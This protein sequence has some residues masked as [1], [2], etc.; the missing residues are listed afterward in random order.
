MPYLDIEGEGKTYY[1]TAGPENGAP[2]LMIHGWCAS[3]R[4]WS[5]QMHALSAS[6]WRCIAFDAL[7]HGRSSK[8]V[9]DLSTPTLFRRLD[10]LMDR[11]GLLGKPLAV[12]G[13]SAGGGIAQY[14]YHRYPEH[15]K[16]LVLL[17]TGYRMRDSLPRTLIWSYGPLYAMAFFNPVT[18]TLIMPGAI[19]SADIT[20]ALL[21]TN[22]N[23]TR[24]WFRDVLRTPPDVAAHEIKE[25]LR[26]ETEHLLQEI[27]AP[28]CIIGS[29]FDPLAPARQSVRMHELIP[30]SELHILHLSGHAGKISEAPRVNRIIKKFLEK[31]YPPKP[32]P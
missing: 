31:H 1:E 5:G 7:G 8:R 18:K 9:R 2:L 29:V 30:D 16:A 24:Q 17:H 4:L 13:H 12:L 27:K 11:L 15:I 25:I 19:M 14:L 28:V 3:S 23:L 26:M 10:S 21:G 32:A 6:G 22:R 20:A